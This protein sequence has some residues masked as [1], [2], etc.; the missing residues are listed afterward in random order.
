MT[1]SCSIFGAL[2]SFD[3]IFALIALRFFLQTSLHLCF[4]R[5][6]NSQSQTVCS[7]Q[8]F[9]WIKYS[10]LGFMCRDYLRIESVYARECMGGELRKHSARGDPLA[11]WEIFPWFDC[12]TYSTSPRIGMQGWSS[13]QSRSHNTSW[14]VEKEPSQTM[15]RRDFFLGIWV[16]LSSLH[17]MNWRTRAFIPLSLVRTD[18]TKI[19]FA[20]VRISLPAS[21]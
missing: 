14:R 1:N 8:T 13:T 21:I 19:L 5:G 17:V 18:Y 10:G 3:Q 6:T 9:P 2:R 7:F 15:K 11:K 12:F 16:R 4:V 20:K